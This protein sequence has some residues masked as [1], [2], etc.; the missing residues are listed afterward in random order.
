MLPM[1]GPAKV[2]LTSFKRDRAI[3][4]KTE[5]MLIEFMRKAFPN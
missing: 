1:F 2:E 4:E 3:L 5:P